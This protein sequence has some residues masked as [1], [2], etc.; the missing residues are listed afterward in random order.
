G[1]MRAVEGFNPSMNTR[2]STYASYWIKQSIRRT[3]INTG[4]TIR[5]P[6]YMNELLIKWRRAAA[7]LHDELGRTPTKEE[8][9]ESLNLSKKKL[10]IIQKAIRIFNAS[11]ANGSSEN[12]TMIDETF[13]D[14]SVPSPEANLVRKDDLQQIMELLD[15]MEPREAAVLRLRFG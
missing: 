12:G 14:D 2:F 7:K 5:I 4:K 3:V 10:A 15:K 1:L 13:Q 11:P 9:A 6:A 8:I